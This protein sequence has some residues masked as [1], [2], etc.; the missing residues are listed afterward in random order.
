M[1]RSLKE[2]LQNYGNENVRLSREVLKNLMETTSLEKLV[3]QLPVQLPLSV[4]EKEMILAGFGLIGQFKAEAVVL[5]N[6][7]M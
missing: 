5:A 4:P 1:L 2:L 3:Q 6:E 7:A